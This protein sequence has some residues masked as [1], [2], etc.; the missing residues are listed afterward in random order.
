M[1]DGI[2]VKYLVDELK[3]IENLRINKVNSITNDEIYFEL[4]NKKKLYIS[5]NSNNM[6]VRLTNMPL[7]NTLI[8]N[9]FHTQLK[10]YL[11]SSIITKIEQYSYDRVIEISLNSFTELGY[12]NKIKLIIELYGRNCNM[13]LINED[14]TIIDV[15]R[16]EFSETKDK[17][18]LVP[19]VTYKYIE[20]DRL[21][22]Y[23]YK[24]KDFEGKEFIGI[25]TFLYKEILFNNTL[26]II[27]NKVNP[28][29]IK[30]NNK[31]YFY[32]FDLKY[33]EGERKYFQ[34]LSEM[35]EYFFYNIKNDKN[36]TNEKIILSNYI[37]KELRKL[38]EKISKQENELLK[39]KENLDLEKTGNLLASN[40]YLIKKGD[41]S[42]IVKNFYDNDKDYKINLDPL[43]SP[44]ENLKKIFNKYQK[45]K[46]AI[47]EIQKQIDISNENIKYY[48]C[49][50]DQ[51]TI[52]KSLDI[53]EI[54]NELNIKRDYTRKKARKSK[55]NFL[56]FKYNDDIIY[57]GKN[58]IQNNYI[59][60]NIATKQDYFFHV[61]G[62]PGSHVILKTLKLTDDNIF[63]TST[64]ASYYSSRRE[65]SN[66][67]VD[68]TS[69]KNVKRI[70]GIK[71]S[72]VNYTNFKSIFVKPDLDSIKDKLK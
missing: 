31:T 59:T 16:R 11:Q 51:I 19:K 29:V 58:N 24:E 48:N 17:R 55:P 7:D 67:I 30:S 23:T 10:K 72:F 36:E 53:S 34:T 60:H 13:I 44:N 56:T 65:S 71:G 38:T 69:M 3:Q 26:D 5:M 61:Q 68:Y 22:P 27:N 28:V 66:V 62:V 8:T 46:R 70:P 64:I 49:I 42:I 45:S 40:L 9:T 57:V 18:M 54:Y 43:L 50:L 1:I 35:L 21:N 4:Q 32:A 41:S 12:I 33:L 20:S 47:D 15:F 6:H 37:H 25:S 2:F 14:N 52:S 63:I 39:A